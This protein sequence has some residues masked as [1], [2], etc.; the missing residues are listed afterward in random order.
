[1]TKDAEYFNPSTSI[2]EESG[3]PPAKDIIEGSAETAKSFLRKDSG[4]FLILAAKRYSITYL[5]GPLSL[6]YFKPGSF[7]SR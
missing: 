7:F 3:R 2:R 1:M 4:A 6:N 5:F